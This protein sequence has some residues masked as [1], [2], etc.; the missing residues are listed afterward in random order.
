LGT[1]FMMART[2]DW[3]TYLSI[4]MGFSLIPWD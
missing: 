4:F 2:M 1:S 3:R